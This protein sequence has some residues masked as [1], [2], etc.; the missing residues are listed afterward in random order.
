MIGKL[1]R[2]HSRSPAALRRFLLKDGD[3]IRTLGVP[4]GNFDELAWWWSRYA[5]VKKRVAHLCNINQRSI[6]GRNM[7]L[8]SKFYGSFRYW[9]F[10]MIMPTEII[11][12]IESDAKRLLWANLPALEAC[13]R[14][15]HCATDDSHSP[16][17]PQ[18]ETAAE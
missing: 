5:V 16:P 1:A 8:Q 2:H 15:G 7:I 3:W 6:T 17:F 18:A 14:M 11:N 13:E 12:A 4:F 9:L 10:S